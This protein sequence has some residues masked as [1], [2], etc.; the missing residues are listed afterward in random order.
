M[1]IKTVL[2]VGHKALKTENRKLSDFSDTILRKLVKD[3]KD[4]LIS[5]NLIGIAAPQ[6][7]QNYMV[8]VTQARNTKFR[9]IGK[10]DRFRVYINPTITHYSKK[11]SVMYEGCGSVVN[12]QLFGSVKRPSLIEVEAYDE[13]GEKFRLRCDGILAR[14]IQHEMDHLV[15]VEFLEKVYDYKALMAGEYYIKFIKNS[16]EH[17]EASKITVVNY[18]GQAR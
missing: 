16:K 5:A 15:G 11:Q 18:Y 6:I 2:Q 1:A 7:G 9:N 14:V 10:E 3:L 4:T 13:K 12:S 17:R 8:F